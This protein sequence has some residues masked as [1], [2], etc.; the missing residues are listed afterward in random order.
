MSSVLETFMGTVDMEIR[1]LEKVKESIGPPYELAVRKIL[2]SKGK[3]IT[4]GIG[5]SG[6]IARKIA[7]TLSSTGTP[8]VFLH[9]AEALHGDL[10]LA[11]KE[12][13]VLAISKSGESEE[14]NETVF[15]LK[16]QGLYIM[17]LTA[18][19]KSTLADLCDL[20]LYT[21][22]ERE[23]C[24]LDLAPTSS[25]T[26]AL[27][28]GDALA[29]TLMKL[30]NFQS[31]DFARNHPAG[32][33]GRRLLYRV[34]DVMIA[35]PKCPI[36]R[37]EHSRFVDVL[38]A[39]STYGLG[40]VLFS[41]DGEHLAGILTDGDIRRL[42]EKY[43]RDVFEVEIPAVMNKNFLYTTVGERAIDVLQ[44]MEKRE[45][46]LN[47]LPVLNQD[48]RFMGLVRLHELVRIG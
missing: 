47:V 19:E 32:S 15:A 2:D 5:K 43:G 10:G 40:I 44:F 33:L 13:V 9:P 41:Q 17:A 3:V 4:T 7:A 16:K 30:R 12:D 14:L 18:R 23:A 24:P 39:L 26:V 21:P 11:Q 6:H 36:L 28:L 25:T 20:L 34:E 46:P 27:V 37:P 48:K 31:E 29:M 38:S 22:I 35:S 1:A 42:V 8:A 45:K